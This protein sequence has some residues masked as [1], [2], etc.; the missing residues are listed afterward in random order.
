M[1]RRPGWHCRLRQPSTL[2]WRSVSSCLSVRARCRTGTCS[3]RPVRDDNVAG[4]LGRTEPKV[5]A[6]MWKLYRH[7]VRMRGRGAD[8]I[9]RTHHSNR[10]LSCDGVPHRAV[11]VGDVVGG[12]HRVELFAATAS[13]R[14]ADSHGPQA[15]RCC[16]HCV[17]VDRRGYW[18]HDA[19]GSA[20][21]KY[22]ER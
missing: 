18:C 22:E 9:I 1:R 6:M 8:S 11:G 5:P 3:R 19:P 12:G 7:R 2:P 15:D 16:T 21:C 10:T 17:A 14:V 4:T 20:T 13:V